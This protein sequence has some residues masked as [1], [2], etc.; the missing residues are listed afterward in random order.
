MNK[1]MRSMI[2]FLAAAFTF[3]LAG[4]TVSTAI[5]QD[6]AA[7][8]PPVYVVNEIDVTD[9][10]GF[11]AYVSRQQPLIEKNGGRYIIRGGTITAIDGTPPK[12]FTVYVFDS[13]DRMLAWKND[14][15]QKEIKIIRD[16]AAKFRSFA[17]EGLAK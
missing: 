6:K 7:A 4:A 8:K 17:V 11:K 15:A 12:R 5:A 14:P 16:K 9:E 3:I 13:A 2:G 1:S 10:T